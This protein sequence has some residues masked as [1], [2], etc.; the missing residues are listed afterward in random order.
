[1]LAF[2]LRGAIKAVEFE[3]T[4]EQKQRKK[5]EKEREGGIFS[6]ISRLSIRMKL[7]LLENQ[8]YRQSRIAI[9]QINI[10]H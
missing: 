10:Q 5:K 6:Y 1:M 8:S 3:Y 4:S 2:F 7:L 9:F